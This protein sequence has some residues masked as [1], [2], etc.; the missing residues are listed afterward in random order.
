VTLGCAP[1][2]R[3]VPADAVTNLIGASE[4]NEIDFSTKIPVVLYTFESMT[5]PPTHRPATAAVRAAE[6]SV[7]PSPTA[8][9]HSGYT[10]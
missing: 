10:N 3:S 5:T 6:S 4:T 9:N 1:A 7:T 8:P 2:A